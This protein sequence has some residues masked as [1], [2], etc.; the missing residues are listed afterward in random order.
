MRRWRIHRERVVARIRAA[1]A[2][3]VSL[4][5][6]PAGFGKSIALRSAFGAARNAAFYRVPA[7]TATLLA[8]LRGRTDAPESDVPGAHLSFA[9][10]YERAIQTH[11]RAR[12]LHM[13]TRPRSSALSPATTARAARPT[14]AP[15]ESVTT[16]RAASERRTG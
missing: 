16:A 6:A 7:D 4:L 2:Q 5:V 8:F 12:R 1:A 13:Q 14:S 10:A 11:R 9:I 3:R 15:P